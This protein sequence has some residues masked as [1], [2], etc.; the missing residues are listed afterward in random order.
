MQK[1][2][3]LKDGVSPEF[4]QI[5]LNRMKVG[6]RTEVV[7]ADGACNVSPCRVKGI[8]VITVAFRKTCRGLD[9]FRQCMQCQNA[10]PQ[11]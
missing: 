9:T 2:Q 8:G 1:S 4:W 6:D 11:K 7:F 5:S 3:C 10:A